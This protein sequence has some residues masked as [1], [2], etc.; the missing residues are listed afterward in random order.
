MVFSKTDF[1]LR[2]VKKR[3]KEVFHKHLCKRDYRDLHDKSEQAF[4]PIRFYNRLNKCNRENMNT[5]QVNK[6]QA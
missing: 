6:V 1:F 3:G 5:E 4:L 2:S